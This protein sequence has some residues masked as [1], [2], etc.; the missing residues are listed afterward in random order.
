MIIWFD[1][2]VIEGTAKPAPDTCDNDNR[3][4]VQSD[5]ATGQEHTFNVRV[6]RP[7]HAGEYTHQTT[8]YLTYYFIFDLI[9][10]AQWTSW[11]KTA[12]YYVSRPGLVESLH[13]RHPDEL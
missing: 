7:A 2:E 11:G 10:R 8:H 6:L 13:M 9:S 1:G 3:C 5:I 12:S 4:Y